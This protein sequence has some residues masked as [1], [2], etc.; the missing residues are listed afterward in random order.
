MQRLPVPRVRIGGPRSLATRKLAATSAAKLSP[1]DSSPTVSPSSPSSPTPPLSPANT[2]LERELS[3]ERQK[4]KELLNQLNKLKE[5]QLLKEKKL[6]KEKD[7]TERRKIVQQNKKLKNEQIEKEKKMITLNNKLIQEKMNIINNL[8]N[9]LKIYI[10]SPPNPNSREWEQKHT[11][12]RTLPLYSRKEHSQLNALKNVNKLIVQPM[13]KGEQFLLINNNNNNYNNN[14][15]PIKTRCQLRLGGY[16]RMLHWSII[17]DEGMYR[18]SLLISAIVSINVISSKIFTLTI[19]QDDD[20][21]K[22]QN[23]ANLSFECQN[24]ADLETWVSG[25]QFIRDVVPVAGIPHM[26]RRRI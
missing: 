16:H 26:N 3:L 6:Q 10:P 5:I 24:E 12:V 22:Q 18:G 9:A 19:S 4:T 8:P 14:N 7:D 20:D 11:L 2:L 13:I 23:M 21:G 15:N 25:L 17:N 1:S